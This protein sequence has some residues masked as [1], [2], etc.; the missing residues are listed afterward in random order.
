MSNE[1]LTP[2]LEGM[3]KNLDLGGKKVRELNPYK[4]GTKPYGEFTA[5]WNVA[6]AIRKLKRR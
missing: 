6:A 3:K 2:Y 5:G 1:K 4:P